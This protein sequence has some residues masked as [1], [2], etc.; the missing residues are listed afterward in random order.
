MQRQLP[1]KVGRGPGLQRARS[2]KSRTLGVP[3]AE[4][5]GH[6]AP[7]HMRGFGIQARGLL[8]AERDNAGLKNA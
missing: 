5:A 8:K 4:A 6:I 1:P 7:L 3:D 2:N